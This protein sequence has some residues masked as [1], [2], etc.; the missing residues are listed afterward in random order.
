[1][2]IPGEGGAKN[3]TLRNLTS[4]ENREGLDIEGIVEQVR[5]GG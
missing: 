3:L 2:I 5:G 1:M 4:R